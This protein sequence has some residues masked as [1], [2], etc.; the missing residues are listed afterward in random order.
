LF[1]LYA[2]FR[3][4]YRFVFYNVAEDDR[5]DNDENEYAE[6]QRLAA[7]AR[8]GVDKESGPKVLVNGQLVNGKTTSTEIRIDGMM[9]RKENRRKA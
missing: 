2:I 9:N 4:A 6:E 8:E 1:W 5:S 7:L 3:I